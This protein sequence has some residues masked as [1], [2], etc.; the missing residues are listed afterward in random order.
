MTDPTGDPDRWER[1]GQIVHAALERD[2][3]AR[4]AFLEEACGDDYELREQVDS[5]LFAQRAGG[6]LPAGDTAPDDQLDLLREA[7]GDRYDVVREIGSGG[8]ATVYLAHDRKHNR[9]VAIKVLHS[10][11]GATLGGERFLREIEIAAGL[12]TT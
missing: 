7:L 6:P 1:I 8:M 5:L 2:P 4:E 12:H 11:L 3:H 9:E 10:W